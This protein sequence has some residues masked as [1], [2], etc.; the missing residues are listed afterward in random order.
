MSA[1]TKTS[2][3]TLVSFSPAKPQLVHRP[4]WTLWQITGQMNLSGSYFNVERFVSQ[5]EAMPRAIM[6]TGFTITANK[7]ASGGVTLSLSSRMFFAKRPV[8]ATPTPT[9]TPTASAGKLG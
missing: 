9:P 8:G 1:A 7:E 6:V 3:V 5:L 4:V 2:D